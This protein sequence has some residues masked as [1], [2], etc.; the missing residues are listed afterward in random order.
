ML[1]KDLIKEFNEYLIVEKKASKNTIRN[2]THDVNM[3]IEYIEKEFGLVN[4]N[5]I[6]KDHIRIF[7]KSLSNLSTSTVSRIMVSMRAFYK[8]MLKEEYITTNIMKYFDL[9]KPKKKLPVVLSEKEI[10]DLLN[11][12]EMNNF[13]SARNRAMIELLYA[14]GLRVSELV[15][16]SIYQL[17]LKM[18]YLSVIGK[19]D[20]ERLLPINDYTCDILSKYINEYRNVKLDFKDNDLLFF[21]NK[22][23]PITREY[24]YEILKKEINKTGITKHVSPHTIRHTFATHL[25]NNGADLRSIQELLG[26]SDLSTTTIYTHVSNKHLIEDYN[27][28]QTRGKKEE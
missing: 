5:D 4:I 25:Y 1:A 2:Y 18:K 16:L 13:P 6:N 28:F 22:F 17:N 24:F 20:K 11:N 14:T 27:R 15:S 10:N 23:Q 3:F 9:P 7:L 8:F 26:H 19:G 12:I 21:N